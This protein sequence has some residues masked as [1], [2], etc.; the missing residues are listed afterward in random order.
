MSNLSDESDLLGEMAAGSRARLAAIRPKAQEL[1]E[2]ARAAVPPP[3]LQ[4]QGFDLIAE[5]KLSSPSEGRLAPVG[6]DELFFAVKQGVTYASAGV[7]AV[8]VL[9]EPIKFGGSLEHLAAVAA[10]VEIPVM[11]KD[12]LVDPLQVYEARAHGAGGVVDS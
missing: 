12:F 10:S 6:E 7:A 4:R 5:V 8:S 11:R 2:K 1:M 9:T 3:V